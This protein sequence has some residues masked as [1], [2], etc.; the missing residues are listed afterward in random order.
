[1]ALAAAAVFLLDRATKACAA[2][3]LAD[4]PPIR[5]LGGAVELV[6][7]ENTGGF[8]SLGGGLPTVARYAVFVVLVGAGLAAAAV[9][10][11]RTPSLGPAR[12]AAAAAILAGGVSN[13]LDRVARGRVVDFVIL[14][15]GPLHT[16]V[17]NLADVAILVGAAILLWRG[18]RTRVK[19]GGE[20][21]GPPNRRS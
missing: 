20:S 8:L 14:R 17:F 4:R 16:G 11:A 2:S 19:R 15:A 6:L 12:S 10:L 1:M 5:F 3:S 7:S 13:L 21:A 18:L 9:W